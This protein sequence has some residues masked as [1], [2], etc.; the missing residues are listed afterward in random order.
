MPGPELQPSVSKVYIQGL[1][2]HR[3]IEGMILRLE[4]RKAEN[5]SPPPPPL[6]SHKVHTLSAF[7]S[8]LT[9]LGKIF[10]VK[11]QTV[12]TQRFKVWPAV[13]VVKR[14]LNTTHS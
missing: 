2:Q 1:K 12:P 10:Q 3:P 6:A 7:F 5:L 4:N 13:D 9:E 11:Q 8:S 14:S